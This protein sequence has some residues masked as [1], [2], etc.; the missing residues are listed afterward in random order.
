M[1]VPLEDPDVTTEFR[2]VAARETVDD[3]ILSNP[4]MYRS[5]TAR[6]TAERRQAD[7]THGH[8]DTTAWAAPAFAYVA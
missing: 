8:Q 6:R 1:T 7:A 4:C 5:E 2:K 3:G